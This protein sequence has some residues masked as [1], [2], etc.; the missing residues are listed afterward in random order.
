[1][2]FDLQSRQCESLGAKFGELELKTDDGAE[3]K[4][5]YATEL[6]EDFYR[7]Q[8]EVMTRVVSNERRRHHCISREKSP[9]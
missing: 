2:T 1:M 8:R 5:G 9:V 4:G 7:K 3:D 6:G